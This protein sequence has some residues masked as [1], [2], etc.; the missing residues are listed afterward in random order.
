KQ[1]TDSTRRSSTNIH[2]VDRKLDTGMKAGQTPQERCRVL[3]ASLMGTAVESYDFFIY[4]SAAALIFGPQF[5]PTDDPLAGT[6]AAFATFA[7]GFIA[8]PFGGVIMGHFGDRVGRKSMLMFSMMLMGIATVGIGL[9]PNYAAIGVWAPILLVLLR[10][11]Q[12]VGV[13][14]EWGGAVLMAV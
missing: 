13:G 11:L 12:G 8:R 2:V 14:G 3:S 1:C 5:F 9:L 10:L 7:V 6:L 4:G